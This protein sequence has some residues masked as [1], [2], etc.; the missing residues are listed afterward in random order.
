[1]TLNLIFNFYSI[2]QINKDGLMNK[3]IYLKK[4]IK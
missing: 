3:F 4:Y 1:M 2:T